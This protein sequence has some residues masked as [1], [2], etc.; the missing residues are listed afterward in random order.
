MVFYSFTS[1]LKRL[2]KLNLYYSKYKFNLINIWK[3]IPIFGIVTSKTIVGIIKPIN[4][5][6]II[7]SMFIIGIIKSINI[8][9]IIKSRQQFILLYFTI[10]TK[11]EIIKIL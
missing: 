11:Q 8:I 3:I 2:F 10:E 9:E 6:E 1:I 4:I 5:I 7:K